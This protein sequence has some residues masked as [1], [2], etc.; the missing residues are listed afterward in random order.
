MFFPLKEKKKK[1]SVTN[2]NIRK[3]IYCININFISYAKAKNC[4]KKTE[5]EALKSKFYGYFLLQYK[6][7]ITSN[8]YHC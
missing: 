7:K 2:Y 3:V 8:R 5:L 6:R 1:I 4:I